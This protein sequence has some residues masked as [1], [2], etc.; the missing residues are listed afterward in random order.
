MVHFSLRLT[1]MFVKIMQFIPM[2]RHYRSSSL[3]TAIQ[4]YRLGF[5]LG[6]GTQVTVR[7]RCLATAIAA[8]L[9]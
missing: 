6:R 3:L 9:L 7:A 8:A 1:K 4:Q 5:A 2:A